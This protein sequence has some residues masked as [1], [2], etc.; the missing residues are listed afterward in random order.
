MS[1]DNNTRRHNCHFEFDTDALVYLG[2][3]IMKATSNNVQYFWYTV[4]FLSFFCHYYYV[5]D[6]M[7]SFKKTKKQI[8]ISYTK[9]PL[10]LCLKGP[11]AL[12]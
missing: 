2:C 6:N 1:H 4:M 12:R 9:D 10:Q 11:L 8:I 7:F 5:Y 3:K